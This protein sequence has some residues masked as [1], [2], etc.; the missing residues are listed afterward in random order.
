M[1]VFTTIFL[2]ETLRANI[3]CVEEAE[4]LD[5]DH[6]ALVEFKRTLRDRIAMLESSNWFEDDSLDHSK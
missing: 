6:S 2:A 3:Q 4:E 5:Q 1:Q